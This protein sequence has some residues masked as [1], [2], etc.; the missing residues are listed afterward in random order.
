MTI[1]KVCQRCKQDKELSAFNK[2]SSSTDGHDKW[3]RDCKKAYFQAN[4]EEILIKQ[5]EYYNAN[6]SAIAEKT[7]GY[8]AKNKDKIKQR[9]KTWKS[10]NKEHTRAWYRNMQKRRTESDELFRSSRALRR[11][12]HHI[13]NGNAP[14]S[15]QELIG[16]TFEEALQHLGPKPTKDAHIDHICPI[17]QAQTKEEQVLLCHYTN[18]Q[19]LSRLENIS[20][21]DSWSPR[22]EEL[23]KLLLG[24]DWIFRG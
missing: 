9:V 13:F 1:S 12:I 19:W 23:C 4:K 3:C 7:K 6:K 20:K 15:T 11:R 10:E 22:G 24:R 2:M 18:F 16:C 21:N 14:K 8:Y 5:K 17:S